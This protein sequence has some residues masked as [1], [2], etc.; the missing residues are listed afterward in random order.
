[1][2]G[3]EMYYIICIILLSEKMNMVVIYFWGDILGLY[4]IFE[5]GCVWWFGYIGII[6]GGVWD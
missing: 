5:G 6:V 4:F 2:G 3:E 1:M